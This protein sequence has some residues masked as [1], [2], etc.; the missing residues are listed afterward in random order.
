MISSTCYDLKQIR[1]NLETFII[2]MGYEPM[3]SDKG[4]IGYN[5]TETLQSDCFLAAQQCDI[6]VGV[7]GGRFGSESTHDDSVTMREMTTAL[8]HK[9]QIYVFVDTSVLTEYRTYKLNMQKKGADFAK[10]EIEYDSVNDTRIFDFINKMYDHQSERVIVEGFQVAA[11]I[12]GFLKK[13][14]AILFQASL[15][16]KERDAQSGAYSKISDSADKLESLLAKFEN[17]IVYLEDN[18]KF[19]LENHNTIRYGLNPLLL[20]LRRHLGA[21]I[22]VLIQTP[23]EVV[24][25]RGYSVISTANMVRQRRPQFHRKSRRNSWAIP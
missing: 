5:I 1:E 15:N 13:Q 11:D 16:Q 7:V 20:C 21:K 8:E 17:N 2:D 14:W 23:D 10:K 9:K 6:L 18:T 24:A 12:S 3:R 4:D 19:L 22:T 25:Q